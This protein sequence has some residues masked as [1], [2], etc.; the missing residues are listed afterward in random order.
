LG[1]KKAFENLGHETI[2][3][4]YDEYL[5]TNIEKLQ[6]DL[7]LK[8]DEVKPDLIFFCLFR[9]QFKIETLNKL[10]SKYKTLNWFGDDSW[11]FEKF[12]T[13]YAPSFTYCVTTDKFSLKKYRDIGVHNIIR[14]QWA[15]IDDER[16]FEKKPYKYDVSFV[17]GFNQYRNWFVKVLK[18]HGIEVACFGNGWLNGPL[19]NDGM[20]ELFQTT[21]INLNISN[22]ACYDIRYLLSHPKNLAHT[23]ISTKQSSQIK[24]RNF[25]I[26]YYGG[27][28]L[29]DYAPTIE[30]YYDI[31]KE[32]SCYIAPDE[33]A[34]Q[35][36]YYLDNHTEREQIRK[37]GYEK[38]MR[39]YTYTGQMKKVLNEIN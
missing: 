22:S 21:K 39:G 7:L 38:A 3:F 32:I 19:S 6:S 33:A 8:A 24:A 36:R 30:E 11:R 20:I 18:K 34:S 17:G 35:I 37:S 9:D 13:T 12:T 2:P 29:T 28:Q 23:L 4:F 27:F 14:A 10:K 5:E 15:A 16:V 26:N 1:F 25:E 31:G